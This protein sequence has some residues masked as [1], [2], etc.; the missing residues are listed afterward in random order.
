MP[1]TTET[2]NN[3]QQDPL[4]EY[5]AISKR[6]GVE[7]PSG[8][9]NSAAEYV[10]YFGGLAARNLAT[11]ELLDEFGVPGLGY[12]TETVVLDTLHA[13]A[14]Q[15][16]AIKGNF[17]KYLASRSEVIRDNAESLVHPLPPE[18]FATLK[19]YQIYL[20]ATAG[21]RAKA[22]NFYQA[23]LP[24]ELK[25]QL[26]GQPVA[27]E[28]SDAEV[29]PENWVAMMSRASDEA[30]GNYALW[31]NARNEK[32]SKEESD[33]VKQE[34]PEVQDFVNQKV[35]DGELPPAFKNHLSRLGNLRVAVRDPLHPY[36]RH[37]P[38]SVMDYGLHSHAITRSPYH[39]N[40]AEEESS[41]IFEIDET[42]QKIIRV[43]EMGHALGGATVKREP[44]RSWTARHLSMMRSQPSP[45]ADEGLI[46]YPKPSLFVDI[47][48][49]G[50]EHFAEGMVLGEWD[51]V[52][53]HE[54]SEDRKTTIYGDARHMLHAILAGGA[55]PISLYDYYDSY[56]E[57]IL[58]GSLEKNVDRNVTGENATARFWQQVKEA[59]G[60]N[61][62]SEFM[63]AH[64]EGGPRAVTEL[65]YRKWEERN[66]R[67]DALEYESMLEAMDPVQTKK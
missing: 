18:A 66:G 23:H 1:V 33:R 28:A 34:I 57:D 13:Q 29:E 22:N 67:N 19:D 26:R 15:Q 17:Q 53:P 36:Y 24:E 50:T 21:G 38:N 6:P 20:E 25:L 62:V 51:K 64:K 3:P 32:L 59:H 37:A 12:G 4:S 9:A 54:R 46:A 60:D 31:L 65:I 61:A 55:K 45:S 11:I 2:E 47:V 14:T 16:L 58:I 42:G 56:A 30:I 27:S 41:G 49:A 40:L 5:F 10:S 35:A 43:H 39:V 8:A 52:S 63:A 48:E 7:N 44:N